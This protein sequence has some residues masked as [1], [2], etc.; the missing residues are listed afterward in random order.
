MLRCPSYCLPSAPPA[1][2]AWVLKLRRTLGR[3]CVTGYHMQPA[4]L[5][6]GVVGTNP[7]SIIGSPLDLW[8]TLIGEV[9][10][11]VRAST[12]VCGRSLNAT[13][14]RSLARMQQPIL[15]AL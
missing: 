12:Q 8:T 2:L 6:L 1:R 13:T 4:D 11:A 14:R 10:G 7:F 5:S 3:D 15:L 9:H